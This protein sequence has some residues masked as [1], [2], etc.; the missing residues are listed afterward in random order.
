MARGQISDEELSSGLKGLGGFGA[1]GGAKVVKDSPF[2]DSRSEPKIV[3]VARAPE[4]PAVAKTA[5]VEAERATA[6]EAK[7]AAAKVSQ[8][9][10]AAK[11][12]VTERKAE[13]QGRRVADVYTERVTLQ[14]SP[15]MRDRV[16]GLAK[17]LQ[18]SKTGKE[19]RI[20][21][22]TV[23]RVAIQLLLKHYKLVGGD[24]PNGEEELLDAIERRCTWK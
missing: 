14:L 11:K 12:S 16:D 8:R 1:L 4:R 13:A 7:A 21:A 3:E 15:E 20:T 23:M 24:V 9:T 19:E 18:R 2:R 10:F 5:P 17:E 22:N 6:A